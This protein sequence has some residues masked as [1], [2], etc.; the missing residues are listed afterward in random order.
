MSVGTFGSTGG[1]PGGG[2]PMPASDPLCVWIADDTMF[3]AGA[4]SSAVTSFRPA[5]ESLPKSSVISAARVAPLSSTMA[6]T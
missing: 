6:R 5:S 1:V 3:S 4:P 2:G